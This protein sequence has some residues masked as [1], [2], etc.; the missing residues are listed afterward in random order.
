MFASVTGTNLEDPQEEVDNEWKKTL[1][2]EQKEKRKLARRIIK[3]I[4]PMLED[5]TKKESELCKKPFE[6][7]LKALDLLSLSSRRD[8][9][10]ES[11]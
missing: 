10:A 8:S 9:I 2:S 5:A 4:K 7:E 1:T 3:A 11:G 6:M